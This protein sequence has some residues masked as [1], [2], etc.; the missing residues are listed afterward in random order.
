MPKKE[1][2]AGEMQN[3]DAKNGR[4][5]SGTSTNGAKKDEESKKLTKFQ[6][7]KSAFEDFNNKRR[8]VKEEVSDDE[9]NQALEDWVHE[10]TDDDSVETY[11]NNISKK[12]KVDKE[13]V[14]DLILKQAPKGTDRDTQFL[15]IYDEVGESDDVEHDEDYERSWGPVKDDEE[16]FETINN[17]RMG[18][19]V[20][21]ES[22]IKVGDEIH[23]IDKREWLKVYDIK[24]DTV[25]LRGPNTLMKK[26]SRK[27]FEEMKNRSPLNKKES[28]LPF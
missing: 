8:G 20:E 13:R 22:E 19:N 3:Y 15:K 23:N 17:K 1:N 11:A 14:I 16:D 18:K 28:K 27:E 9:I 7:K 12:L 4:Y 5:E 26:V 24:G 6:K 10:A 2:A 25:Y 21:K